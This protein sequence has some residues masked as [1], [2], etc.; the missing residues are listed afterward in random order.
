MFGGGG[1][2][3]GS[4]ILVFKVVS[5]FLPDLVPKCYKQRA[6]IGKA[7]PLSG[8]PLW[9]CREGVPT[10]L[11]V[12]SFHQI[13]VGGVCVAVG[14]GITIS[15]TLP[16]PIV[17]HPQRDLSSSQTQT[18]SRPYLFSDHII[19]WPIAPLE[20]SSMV[21]SLLPTPGFFTCVLRASGITFYPPPYLK[22][23]SGSGGFHQL[24]L[25]NIIPQSLQALLV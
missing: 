4:D 13:S 18:L 12:V 24:L 19:T 14:E 16:L 23:L 5:S 20:K 21:L 2:G 11:G 1:W 17:K 22:I 15:I 6:R 25:K 9:V 8:H 10:L 7:E 3:R